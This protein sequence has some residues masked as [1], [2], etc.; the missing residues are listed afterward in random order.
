MDEAD[1]NDEKIC[2]A[3]RIMLRYRDGQLAWLQAMK[4]ALTN[5]NLKK[6]M[7][8]LAQGPR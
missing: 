7:A 2:E 6:T 3:C 4:D 1:L 5:E 8:F